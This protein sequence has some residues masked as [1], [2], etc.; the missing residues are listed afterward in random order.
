MEKAKLAEMVMEK[1]RKKKEE[2]ERNRPHFEVLRLEATFEKE[3][4]DELK[5]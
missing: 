2:E 4:N 3:I 5:E 1:M